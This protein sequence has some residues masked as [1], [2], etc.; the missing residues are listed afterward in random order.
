MKTSGV[1]AW[2]REAAERGGDR[3][4][5]VFEDDRWTQAELD[6]WASAVAA[7]LQDHG[8]GAGDTVLW[9]LPN[10]PGALVAHEAALLLGAV[11]IP[12]PMLYREHELTA[13]VADARPM[14]VL[15]PVTLGPRAVSEELDR[16]LADTGVRPRVRGSVDGSA[17]GW[18]PVPDRGRA[19][20][21]G[22]VSPVRVA[23][24]A[25]VLILYTSGSTAAPKGVV[26]TSA[27]LA[28]AAA[29][30]TDWCGLSAGDGFITG[31]PVAHIAGLLAASVLPLATGGA[32]T[33]MARWDA[34][35]AA[36]LIDREHSTFSCGATVFLQE[37]V[38]VYEAAGDELAHRLTTFICGGATIPPNLIAR[39]QAQGI[40]AFR[41]WGMTEA[42]M[43]G[44]ARRDDPLELRSQTDGR[45]CSGAEVGTVDEDRQAMPEGS[46]GELRLRAGQQ[47]ARYTDPAATAAQVDAD[48]WFYT[49]DVGHVRDGLITMTGRIKDI[50]NRG[51]EKFSAQDIER[52]IGEHPVVARV[53]GVNRP[54]PPR[55]AG[56]GAA[57][58]LR[59]R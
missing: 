45:V 58:A 29:V 13:I 44:M 42:P 36:R 12:V 16:V 6:A 57:R 24:D 53:A 4:G 21:T 7:W 15:A 20:A 9:H 51:G 34:T 39:A 10:C 52:A 30:I 22:E 41:S 19:G 54:P 40:F 43:V 56:V 37:L 35:A 28:H 59:P 25:P 46:V 33:V 32:A 5:L 50:I 3:A 27:S 14:A 26:H 47:M 8:I 48:G 31:A 23:P 38:E 17:D 1:G 11:S 49:G 2:R 55:R 18:A